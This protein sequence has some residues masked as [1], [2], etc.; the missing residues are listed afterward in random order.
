MLK[1]SPVTPDEVKRHNLARVLR[2]LHEDGELSRS[3][4]VLLTGLNRSTIGALVSD[5]AEAGLVEEVSG[6]GGS[7]GR[8]S[9]VVRIE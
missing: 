2:Y 9:L 3:D 8:P 5:L 7:R 1:P 6:V 4:L